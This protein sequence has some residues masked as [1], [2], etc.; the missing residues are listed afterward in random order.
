MIPRSEDR[1]MSRP[2]CK[3]CHRNVVLVRVGDGLVAT[4]PELIMVIPASNR[5]PS[6]DTAQ[7]LPRIVM[8][9]RQTFARRLHSELCQSYQDRAR[10]E[11]I[12]DEQRA[13]NKKNGKSPR[14][15]SGL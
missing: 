12:A 7:D 11:R 15:N 2:T 9:S 8:A 3:D 1:E 14:R 13:Y 6:Q 5:V 10:R 4:D